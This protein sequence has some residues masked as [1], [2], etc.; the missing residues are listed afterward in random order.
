MSEQ[1]QTKKIEIN[2]S[3]T[4]KDKELGD[5]IRARFDALNIKA[6]DV[7]GT[8]GAGKTTLLER[9]SNFSNKWRFSNQY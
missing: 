1:T 4:A 9:I 3:I 2:K 5:T 6:F 8:I 7:M